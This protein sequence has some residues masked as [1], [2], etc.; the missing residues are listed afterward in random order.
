MGHSVGEFSAACCADSI[1]LSD[2]VRL[3]EFR[4][5]EMQRITGGRPVTMV[6]LFPVHER[7]LL[8]EF[9]EEIQQDFPE[10][11]CSVASI[12][13]PS[14]VVLSGDEDFVMKVSFLSKEKLRVRRLH[15]L[16]V[17]CAFHSP[18]L[19]SVKNELKLV[20]AGLTVKDPLVPL[21]S[22]VGAEIVEKRE[23]LV[24]ELIEQTTK[25]VDWYGC[26]NVAIDHELTKFVELGPQNV[27]GS[28]TKKIKSNVDVISIGTVEDIKMAEKNLHRLGFLN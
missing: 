4:G 21:I 23:D 11:I 8:Q 24:R 17:S 7:E 13:G 2:A 26:V 18:L 16:D 28:L 14:Q 1:S 22:N 27:L 10:R 3:T 20:M 15:K 19:E 25:T 12:N 6:A 9:I 5:K